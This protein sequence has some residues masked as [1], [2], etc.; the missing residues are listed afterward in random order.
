MNCG[1]RRREES[2]QIDP[3]LNDIV[4]AAG[5][6][7]LPIPVE[8]GRKSRRDLHSRRAAIKKFESQELT[9]SARFAYGIA[10]SVFTHEVC[11]LSYC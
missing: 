1:K 10:R 11:E 6:R 3:R 4:V 2:F 9:D 8:E 5:G 7:S